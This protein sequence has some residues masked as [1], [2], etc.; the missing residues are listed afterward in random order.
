MRVRDGERLVTRPRD[1]TDNATPSGTS[2]AVELS[3]VLADL[4]G[5]EAHRRRARHVLETLAE[6]MARHAPAFGHLLGAADLAVDGAVELVLVGRP[7]SDDFQALA[8]TAARRYV[9]SLV[10]DGGPPGD[11]AAGPLRAD[12]PMINGRATA[13]VCRHSTCELPTT[14]PGTLATQ[15]ATAGRR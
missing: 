10:L 15:L 14:D 5:D 8:T 7:E 1:P 3:L 4:T 6:P 11:P 13:Y 9:P 12:R 2:L